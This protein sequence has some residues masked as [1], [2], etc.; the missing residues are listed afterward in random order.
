MRCVHFS[1][2][3]SARP[4][5]RAAVAVVSR[6]RLPDAHPLARRLKMIQPDAR[7]RSTLTGK[8]YTSKVDNAVTKSV[9]NSGKSSLTNTELTHLETTKETLTFNWKE[10]MSITMKPP[11]EDMSQEL[12]W[13]ILNQ[14]FLIQ[15]DP[16]HSENFSNQTT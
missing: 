8:S 2:P 6:R 11:E 14:E 4:R 16:D 3:L 15:S 13:P 10:S 1:I 5:V 7:V 9:P 12:S